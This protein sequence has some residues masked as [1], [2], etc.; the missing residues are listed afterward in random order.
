MLCRSQRESFKPKMWLDFFL[1]QSFHL[2]HSV[3]LF[4]P[5]TLEDDEIAA[6][7]VKADEL[8]AWAADVKEFALQQAL[9]GVKYDGFKV[10]ATASSSVYFRL[11]LP[12]MSSSHT[13]QHLMIRHKTHH[14]LVHKVGFIC[15][16]ISAVFHL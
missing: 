8:A 3:K 12:A 7:L 14:V 2:I 16:H 15:A 1:F 10:S 13:S 9:S 5:A 11:D 6:I 4:L